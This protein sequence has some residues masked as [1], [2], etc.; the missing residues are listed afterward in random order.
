MK[1]LSP[2]QVAVRLKSVPDWSLRGKAIRR[3]FEF[4]GFMPAVDFVNRVARRAERNDHHPDIDI[5]WNKV[6]LVFSTH[7]K[8]SLT[9][10]DFE[11]ARQVGAIFA[12]HFGKT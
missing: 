12:R 2:G 3:Q 1:K 7:S 9:A 6:T 10:L 4:A 5:R 11:S 8:G